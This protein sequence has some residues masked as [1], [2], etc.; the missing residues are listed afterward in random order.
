MEFPTPNFICVVCISINSS[1]LPA[2]RRVLSVPIIPL[3]PTPIPLAF[4][5][6]LEPSVRF[7]SIT[8][9]PLRE[10]VLPSYKNVDSAAKVLS[11]VTQVIM[12]LSTSPATDLEPP[13]AAAIPDITT[14]LAA[15]AS[16]SAA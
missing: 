9:S 16:I 12:A 10:T 13:P 11:L 15:L 4:T 6:P 7:P 3:A 8:R 14:P 1:S 5:T 2:M